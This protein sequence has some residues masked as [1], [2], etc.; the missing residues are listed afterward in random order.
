[1]T[2]IDRGQ[3]V[4]RLEPQQR[5]SREARA[6]ILAAAETLLRE[7]GID[8]FSM[9]AVGK[10]ADMPVGNIYRRFEGKDDL[11]QALKDVVALRIREAV[12]KA[13]QGGDHCSLESYVTAFALAVGDVFSNDEALHRA[14]FDPRVANRPMLE[15]GQ[16]VRQTIFG[17]FLGGLREHFPTMR[18][19]RL[20]SAA[21]VAFSIITN[22]AIFKVR[23]SDP[24]MSGFS[25]AAVKSEYGMAAFAYL[26][27]AVTDTPSYKMS[28]K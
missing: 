4:P 26:E 24:I 12:V 21:K 8:G 10:V 28:P 18:D 15:T 5:R 2:D 1:M 7:D 20:A 9:A 11:L 14:L 22:A 19:E 3:T 25:W 13:V 6:R 23:G 17:F 27:K 16:G